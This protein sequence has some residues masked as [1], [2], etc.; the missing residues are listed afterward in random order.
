MGDTQIN[1]QTNRPGPE[2]AVTRGPLICCATLAQRI[3]PAVASTNAIVA[4]LLVQEA[5]RF[6]TFCC[7]SAA[8][9]SEDGE[10][11][12]YV[13]YSGD[14]QTYMHTFSLERD[15]VRN[16]QVSRPRPSSLHR[17][18]KFCRIIIII[19]A[20]NKKYYCWN[21]Y[22]CNGKCLLIFKKNHTQ[23]C[24]CS[25]SRCGQRETLAADISAMGSACCEPRA[26]VSFSLSPQ[27]CL[28]CGTRRKLQLRVDP[29]WPLTRL[30]EELKKEAQLNKPSL[31]GPTVR[32]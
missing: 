2:A 26:L 15:P 3:V 22:F 10:L 30:L 18:I 11:E 20:N 29:Q 5:F 25:A 17:Q 21:H 4:A 28:V 32:V 12:N 14:S 19:I 9:R 27:K 13:M 16:R 8:D 1:E 24:L 7:C 6:K 23:Y 31:R